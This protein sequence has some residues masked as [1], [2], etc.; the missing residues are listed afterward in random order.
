MLRTFYVLDQERIS[1]RRIGWKVRAGIGYA[2]QSFDDESD[3]DPTLEIGAEYHHPLSN[4]TQFS[5]EFT[6][7]TILKDDDDSYSLRNVMTLTHEISDRID[8]ENDWTVDY[9]KDGLTEQD[10]TV[11]TLS[12]TFI[13]SINNELDYTLSLSS[14]HFSGDEN[15]NNLNGTDTSAFMGLRYRLK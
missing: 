6:A 3:S 5:N 11:S 14:A 7:N 13:Y 12:S 2:Y 1:T 9:I 10:V 4:S 15:I 8:W